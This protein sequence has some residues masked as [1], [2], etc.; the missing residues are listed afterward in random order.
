MFITENYNLQDS[1]LFDMACRESLCL[2]IDGS[3]VENKKELKRYIKTEAPSYE[4][5]SLIIDEKLPEKK[6]SIENERA[7]FDRFKTMLLVNQP[8]LS[9]IVGESIIK[10]VI[11]NVDT[12]SILNEAEAAP[13]G[14]MSGV[15]N[16]GVRALVGTT[17]AMSA[18]QGLMNFFASPASAGVQALLTQLAN[19]LAYMGV[20]AIVALMAYAAYKVYKNYM[21]KAAKACSAKEGQEKKMCMKEFE[22]NALNAQMTD[23]RKGL[24][25]CAKTKNP[26]K[27]REAINKKAM[28]IKEKIDKARSDL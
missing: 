2:M 3:S 20:G 21:T 10:E 8:T 25:A 11:S 26:D 17:V 9:K 5:L 27:C 4:V 23:I 15:G 13:Q 14:A 18:R 19:V 6:F 1:L 12:L 28:K 22:I 7:L 16:T 24:S